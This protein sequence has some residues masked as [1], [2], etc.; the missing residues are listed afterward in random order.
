MF[1]LMEIM[2]IIFL[3]PALM[4]LVYYWTVSPKTSRLDSI[5]MMF[6]LELQLEVFVM[7]L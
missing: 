4:C 6:R 7:H 2:N 1:I 3:A 5:G